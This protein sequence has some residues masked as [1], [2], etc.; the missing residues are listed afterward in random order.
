MVPASGYDDLSIADGQTA[1]VHY[2]QALD[3]ADTA[4][5]RQTFED[6]RAYCERDTLAMVELCEALAAL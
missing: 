2:A 6:L 3:S 5:R 1:A 4:E